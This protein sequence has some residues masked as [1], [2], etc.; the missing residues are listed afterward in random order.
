MFKDR[1]LLCWIFFYLEMTSTEH[2][3]TY[4]QKDFDGASKATSRNSSQATFGLVSNTIR[5]QKSSGEIDS[6][7]KSGSNSRKRRDDSLAR[8]ALTWFSLIANE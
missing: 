6:T 2:E 1:K 4:S 5:T 8:H 3:Q 7:Y